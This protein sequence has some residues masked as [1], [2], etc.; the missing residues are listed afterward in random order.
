MQAHHTPDLGKVRIGR[1]S[2]GQ[3]RRA[4][5]NRALTA[6]DA[7]RWIKRMEAAFDEVLGP[8]PAPGTPRPSP[9]LVVRN[10]RP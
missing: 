10:D 4:V 6:E 3:M 7:A 1:T 2:L 5:E 8:P 9:F